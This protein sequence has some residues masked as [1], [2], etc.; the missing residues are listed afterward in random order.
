MYRKISVLL[1]FLLLCLAACSLRDS[2]TFT[3]SEVSENWAANLEV[4]QTNDNYETQN[5]VL[6]Y[7]GVM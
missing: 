3:F 5:F 2:K 4:T 7:K 1:L 6:E